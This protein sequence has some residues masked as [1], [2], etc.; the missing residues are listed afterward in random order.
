MSQVGRE[1]RPMMLDV[2]PVPI[3]AQQHADGEAMAR[4][5]Q[6][7]PLAVRRAPPADLARQRHECAPGS[8]VGQS[9]TRF[10]DQEAGTR[11]DRR[12]AVPL[13][14]VLAKRVLGGGMQ[15]QQARFTELSM[16]DRQLPVTAS[17]PK[18]VT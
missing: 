10:G 7:W 15:G 16:P 6:P 1:F 3:P 12:A 17:K 11:G 8:P 18:A 14:H 13:C 9:C 5:M 4:I 2:D